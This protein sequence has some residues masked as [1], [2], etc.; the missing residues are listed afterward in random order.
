MQ[1]EGKIEPIEPTLSKLYTEINL[2][3]SVCTG[4]QHEVHK[5]PSTPNQETDYRHP[6][7][8]HPVFSLRL[9][10]TRVVLVIPTF[11]I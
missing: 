10:L 3:T 4:H 7:E 8:C 5:L 6:Q 1:Y 2:Y 9:V 11:N